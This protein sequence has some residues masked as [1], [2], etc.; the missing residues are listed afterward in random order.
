RPATSFPTARISGRN[1]TPA[2]SPR[3]PSSSSCSSGKSRLPQRGRSPARPKPTKRAPRRRTE[4]KAQ[5]SIFETGAGH[6]NGQRHADEAP[7]LGGAGDRC[8]PGAGCDLLLA[9][10]R[11]RRH[12]FPAQGSPEQYR[13]AAEPAGRQESGQRRREE[14]GRRKGHR[15]EGRGMGK[16]LEGAGEA[17]YLASQV[18]RRGQD[19]LSGRHVYY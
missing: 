5:R 15:Q 3:A 19:R 7:I 13:E 4:P 18:R 12:R 1:S 11:G 8:A 10:D 16:G 17:L 9:G 6:E 14:K 2:S